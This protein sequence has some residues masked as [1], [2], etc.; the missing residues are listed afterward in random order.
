MDLTFSRPLYV[1]VELLI[2]ETGEIQ[3]ASASTWAT[4]RG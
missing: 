2:K 4:T 1:N 3:R